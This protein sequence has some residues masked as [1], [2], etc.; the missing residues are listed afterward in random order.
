M[1][2][3]VAKA[4]EAAWPEGRVGPPRNVCGKTGD[5]PFGSALGLLSGALRQLQVWR[6]RGWG[7]ALTGAE[8]LERQKRGDLGGRERRKE[9]LLWGEGAGEVD[10][11]QAFPSEGRIT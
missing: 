9:E 2:P 10:L 1:R 3:A 5:G 8:L 4:A 7:R 11:Q 6:G